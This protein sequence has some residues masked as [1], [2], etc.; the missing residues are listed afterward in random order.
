MNKQTH[1]HLLLSLRVC[2]EDSSQETSKMTTYTR[3]AEPVLE[4]E[5]VNMGIKRK[6]HKN[7]FFH[8]LKLVFNVYIACLGFTKKIPIKSL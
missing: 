4:R 8:D 6:S 1:K 3:V 7:S 2:S 5:T